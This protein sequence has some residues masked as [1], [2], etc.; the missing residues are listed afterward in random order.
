MSDPSGAGNTFAIPAAEYPGGFVFYKMCEAGLLQGLSPDIDVTK[1]W[2]LVIIDDDERRE[3]FLK[4]HPE[5]KLTLQ[6]RHVS[7]D[8]ARMLAK[9]GYGQILTALDP[10]DFNPICVPY[11]LGHKTNVS[12]VVGGSMGD[13][14]PDANNGYILK[15]GGFGTDDRIT[16]IAEIRLLAN[17]SAPAYHVV[18]GEVIGRDNVERI[19]AKL[20][21]IVITSVEAVTAT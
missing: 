15:T 6:F 3:N 12:Y 16:L 5:R 21:D 20:G 14:E 19:L 8:F 1:D 4:K 17:T 2:R 11:I 9:I 13:P 10:G 7:D 18:V